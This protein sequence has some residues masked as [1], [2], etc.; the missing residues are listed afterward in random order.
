MTTH[1]RKTFY[2]GAVLSAALLGGCIVVPAGRPYAGGG[3][4]DYVTEAPPAPQV[5]VVGVAPTPGYIWIGGFWGWAGGRHVWT[6]GYWAA[7]RPGYRW[8]PH[9][10]HRHGPGWRAAPGYWQRH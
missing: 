7:P 9:Q 4:G 3:G 2:A 5:E 6:N 10:W 1:S 8:V